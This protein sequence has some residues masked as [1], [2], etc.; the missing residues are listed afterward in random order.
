[1]RTVAKELE[2]LV[3]QLHP[4]ADAR[5]DF[6]A[7]MRDNLFDAVDRASATGFREAFR[8]RGKGHA[9]DAIKYT[10]GTEIGD[11]CT[12]PKTSALSN[13]DV[14]GV[15]TDLNYKAENRGAP[16]GK[17]SWR[18]NIGRFRELFVFGGESNL[19]G[20]S[21]ENLDGLRTR[22]I[23]IGA[24]AGF[25]RHVLPERTVRQRRA[26]VGDREDHLAPV[27]GPRLHALVVRAGGDGRGLG[28]QRQRLVLVHG[29]R[30]LQG[31][32]EGRL[33]LVHRLQLLGDGVARLEQLQR[34]DVACGV[35]L[36]RG[37][38]RGGRDEAD[39][40]IAELDHDVAEDIAVVDRRVGDHAL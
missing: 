29:D 23:E 7:A 12:T 38:V 27:V 3:N 32:A 26:D 37:A 4:S 5:A 19:D 24:I 22:A 33:L 34:R 14:G 25:F 20:V 18:H 39:A 10:K 15:L 31:P 9:W 1:M 17:A 36:G 2:F 8:H 28:Q 21:Q 16:S 11:E 35:H 30:V 6:E 13:V 40:P